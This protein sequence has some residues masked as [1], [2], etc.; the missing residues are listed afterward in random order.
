MTVYVQSKIQTSTTYLGD[1]D[2]LRDV[3]QALASEAGELRKTL[4]LWKDAATST[5]MSRGSSA[6]P[7]QAAGAP[8]VTPP[9]HATLAYDALDGQFLTHMQ[10]FASLETALSDVS[11][12]LIRAYSLYSD[13]ELK[14]QRFFGESVQALIE[15]FPQASMLGVAVVIP[16]APLF[17]LRKHGTLTPSSFISQTHWIN[18]GIVAGFSAMLAS[19]GVSTVLKGVLKKGGEIFSHKSGGGLAS[20]FFDPKAWKNFEWKDIIGNVFQT[21]EANDLASAVT[22]ASAPARAVID[23]GALDVYEV[24]PQT[25]IGKP[26]SIADALANEERLISQNGPGYATVCIQKVRHSDGSTSWIVMLP[27]SDT[28]EDSPCSGQF[29]QVLSSSSKH[30]LGSDEVKFAR[31]AME[32]A[33]IKKGDSIVLVG[34]S[35]GGITAAALASDL[36]GTYDFTHVVTAASPIANHPIPGK[37]YVTS[38]EMTGDPMSVLDGAENPSRESFLTVQG[39]VDVRGGDGYTAVEGADKLDSEHGMNYHRAAWSNAV[40]TGSPAV[41]KHERHFEDAVE[42]TLVSTR[43]FQGRMQ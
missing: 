31:K 29:S 17:G 37:T 4:S 38:V 32:Q 3:A 2:L 13:A 26:G 20:S 36:S 12:G 5:A 42:G 15:K 7:F 27:D 28:H 18:E 25:T 30:R 1:M 6:C 24:H 22:T 14:A 21:D 39:E 43:Y 33:G 8:S 19:A 23:R 16:L 35:E 11:E 34:A 40:D 10:E 41:E 9:D